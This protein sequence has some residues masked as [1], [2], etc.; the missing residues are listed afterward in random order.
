MPPG[1]NAISG[2]IICEL[3]APLIQVG[4]QIVKNYA[5]EFFSNLPAVDAVDCGLEEVAL[6][7]V[8]LTILDVLQQALVSSSRSVAQMVSHARGPN[9]IVDHETIESETSRVRF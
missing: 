1:F 6:E 2:L 9:L 3:P 5:L 8:I 7:M 4:V